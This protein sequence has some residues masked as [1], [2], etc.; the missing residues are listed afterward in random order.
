MAHA[1]PHLRPFFHW[2]NQKHRY[3]GTGFMTTAALHCGTASALQAP[4]TQVRQ[5]TY[6][7]HPE[8]FKGKIPL[9]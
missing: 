1:R 9:C 2:Y 3:S 8:R 4:C 6:R 5:A 7:I